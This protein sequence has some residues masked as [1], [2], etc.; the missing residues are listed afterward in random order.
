MDLESV[1]LA[2]HWIVKSCLQHNT[3]LTTSKSNSRPS[4]HFSS[5]C[6]FKDFL[7]FAY[8][9]YKPGSLWSF[10]FLIYHFLLW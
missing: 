9:I 1:P 6:Y 5:F 2:D 10:S 8:P 3:S 7:H 4:L